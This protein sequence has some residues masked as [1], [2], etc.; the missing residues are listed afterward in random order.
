MSATIAAEVWA[1]SLARAAARLAGDD[2]S[3]RQRWKSPLHPSSVQFGRHFQ[4]SV[5]QPVSENR[6][7]LKLQP[8]CVLPGVSEF[9]AGQVSCGCGLGPSIWRTMALE[10]VAGLAGPSTIQ[11]GSAS[12]G[13]H[14]SWSSCSWKG[15]SEHSGLQGLQHRQK[16]WKGQKAVKST[17]TKSTRELGIERNPGLWRYGTRI[18]HWQGC[19]FHQTQLVNFSIMETNHCSAHIL[20]GWHTLSKARTISAGSTSLILNAFADFLMHR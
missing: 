19:H 11:H 3:V 6:T 4:R 15:A 2:P 8:L 17:C 12:A 20:P 7:A 13:G 18:T 16:M 9:L 1:G 5:V 14:C 10:G